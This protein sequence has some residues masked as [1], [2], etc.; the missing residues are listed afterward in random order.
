MK[1]HSIHETLRRIR[2]HLGNVML[3]RDIIPAILLITAFC[4]TVTWYESQLYLS[5]TW[6]KI[7]I[8]GLSDLSLVLVLIILIRWFGTLRGWWPWVTY[9]TLAR[10]MGYKLDEAEDRLLNAL[11]LENRLGDSKDAPNRDL[12]VRSI[13]LVQEKLARINTASLI[14]RRYIPSRSI[15]ITLIVVMAVT[16][17]LRP[18][19]MLE[20]AYRLVHPEREFPVPIPFALVAL[21]GDQEVLG[22]DTAQVI[23]ASINAIPPEIEII[24]E[25]AGE[26]EHSATVSVNGDRFTFRFED[27]RDDVT[28]YARYLNPVWFAPWKEITSQTYRIAIIDR[29]VIENLVFHIVPPEYTGE[30]VEYVGGN[31]ADI[32]ALIGSNIQIEGTT[33]LPLKSGWI[34]IGEMRIP[35]E[36]TGNTLLGKFR[37][38]ASATFFVSVLDDR[39]VANSNPI[40]YRFTA[41]PDYPPTLAVLAPVGE[42]MLNDNMTLPVQFDITDD[43]GFS[44]A[45]VVYSIRRPEY[46]TQDNDVYTESVSGLQADR[47]SQRLMY[48]WDIGALGLAPGDVLE[49]HIEVYDNNIVSGPGKA[50]S[51]TLRA[52]VPTLADMFARAN[53]DAIQVD[54]ISQESLEE[55]REVQRTLEEIEFAYLNDQEITY[56]QQQRGKQLVENLDQVLEAIE[57]VQEQLRELE[58]AADSHNLFSESLLQKYDELQ[59]LLQEIMSDELRRA[60]GDLQEA[61]ESMDPNVF[62]NALQNMQFQ[63]SEFEMQIDRFIDIFRQVQAEMR[64]NEVVERLE[65]LASTEAELLRELNRIDEDASNVPGE[66]VTRRTRDLAA[67]HREQEREFDFTRTTMGTAARDIE[68]FSPEAAEQLNDLN[69]SD[70]AGETGE[71]M[72]TGTTSLENLDRSTSQSQMQQTSELLGVMAAMAGDIRQQ[73]QQSTVNDMMAEFQKVMNSILTISRQQ[74]QVHLET[75]DLTTS[76]PRVRDIATQQHQLRLEMSNA[77]EQIIALSRQTFAIT[78]QIGRT[79]GRTNIAMQGAVDYLAGNNISE[80]ARLQ[81]ESM[82]ALNETAL[83]LSNSMADMEASGSAS[84]FEQYLERMSNLSGGQASLNQES[85]SFQLGNMTGISQIE[86]MRR[87]QARQQQLA[88][89]LEEIM[90]DFPNQT[91]GQNGGLGEALREM[92]EVIW[93]YEQRQL[94][95]STIEQQERIL[96]R[97]LDSQRSLARQDFEEDRQGTT[98][99]E[100]FLYSGPTGLPEDLGQREDLVLQAMEKALRSGYSQ[101]YTILIQQYFQRLVNEAAP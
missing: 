8:W 29:P 64:M 76:S 4:T 18:A 62:R 70:I 1:Q 3:I 41:L 19:S 42:V 9:A 27:L 77:T 85:L 98:P 91:G 101:E 50:V 65:N 100:Q 88:Q 95:P 15:L 54:T 89:V 21:S 87:L 97:L 60:M 78:P 74:E 22:G 36:V 68:P 94:T 99:T 93:D 10:Q 32:T 30:R 40:Q 92:E 71:G 57:S 46:L 38:D 26:I 82:S 61:L 39:D 20:A 59:N 28:Y 6:R 66:D 84:G 52:R 31:V 44:N 69:D 63:T 34:Q 16:W 24:W 2:N 7:L 73:F 25:G 47:R 90:G 23:I 53:E 58:A 49:F 14:S 45:Q 37:L 48:M 67:Q 12:V 72:R 81:L 80:A 33:N 43:Y 5:T 11:E 86:L 13:E 75:Q 83:A 51:T 96:S 35:A 17:I 79:I 56:E 55:L